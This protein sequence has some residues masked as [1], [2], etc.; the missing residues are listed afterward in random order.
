[1]FSIL[2]STGAES[3][4]LRKLQTSCVNAPD[5][6]APFAVPIL[7]KD[8]TKTQTCKKLLKKKKNVAK[9]CAIAE[10]QANCQT[11]CDTCS[12]IDNTPPGGEC[13][14]IE[15]KFFVHDVVIPKPKARLCAWYANGGYCTSSETVR[16]M[17]CDT[18]G[19]TSE[20]TLSPKPT[21]QPTLSCLPDSITKFPLPPLF[22]D[23]TK[24]TSCKKMRKKKNIEELCKIPE[25]Q[26]ECE[27]TC[28]SC[29]KSVINAE[30]SDIAAKF[31]IHDVEGIKPKAKVCSWYF[32]NGY[33]DL[34]ET[35]QT[36]CGVSCDTCME[37]PSTEPSVK[38]SM[39]VQPSAEHSMNPS[40]SKQPSVQP[41][42][43]PSSKPS[44]EP[45]SKPS[46][47]PSLI[48]S[49]KPTNIPSV[50][51]SVQ[52]STVPSAV[53]SITVMPTNEPSLS[54]QPSSGPTNTHRPSTTVYPSLEP[55]DIPSNQPSLSIVPTGSAPP[56]DK[57]TLSFQPS[58]SMQPTMQL[59]FTSLSE[60]KTEIDKYCSN[61][62]NYDPIPYG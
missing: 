21:A 18:C 19:G 27:T 2:D 23:P 44:L 16:S 28:S 51:P 6:K 35:V 37:N 31:L 52:P 5:S 56:S 45:S 20:P 62:T 38:P 22:K 17:C 61:Q 58:V 53:P 3:K 14:D 49:D 59:E 41:S 12:I 42:D 39:S 30:C 33:C 4:T 8:P 36:L 47:I 60:L 54:M 50:E 46:D 43:K 29:Y 10:V 55:T 26:I 13:V 9:N 7:N 11:K 57:P 1:M 40:T 34:S 15:L 32:E 25:L 24:T 48:P